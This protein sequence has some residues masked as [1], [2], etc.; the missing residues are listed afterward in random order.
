MSHFDAPESLPRLQI[1]A[2]DCPDPLALAA[3]YSR[4]TGLEVEPLGDFA[5]EQVTWI[6]LLNG[7][8]PTLAFQ[9]IDGYV[10]PT[11][12][13]GAVPQQAHLDLLVA[14]LDAGEAHVLSVGATKDPYQ[15]GET[16]RVY[17]DPVGHRFCLVQAPGEAKPSGEGGGVG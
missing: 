7:S 15:P 1:F 3:F 11:W 6:E 5:P 12:P 17:L 2:L 16:F 10:A 13:E 4:V 8:A 14:D 9:K